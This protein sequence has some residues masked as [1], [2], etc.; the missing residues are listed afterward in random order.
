MPLS[1]VDIYGKILPKTNCGDCGF[2]TCLAFASMVVSEKHSLAG[3]PHIDPQVVETHRRELEAQY[4]AGKWT[5]K[6]M[7][8]D[9]LTWAKERAASMAIEDLP[10]RI[11]GELKKDQEGSYLELPYFNDVILIRPKRVSKKDGADL[12][13][14]F[15]ISISIRRNGLLQI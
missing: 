4:A 9:A 5:Q 11:G 13:M 12:F 7:A 15:F 10:G 14:R 1:V 3:C 6:D 2:T 8:A